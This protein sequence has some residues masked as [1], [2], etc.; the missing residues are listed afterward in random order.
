MANPLAIIG[1]GVGTGLQ[2]YAQIRAA[3]AK[4]QSMRDQ[5]RLEEFAASETEFRS[6]MN[7]LFTKKDVQRV[8]GNTISEMAESGIAVGSGS[9]LE[10]I[11]SVIQSM[12][13]SIM[14]SERE[15]EFDAMMSREKAVS[16]RKTAHSTEQNG[17]LQAIA[18]VLSSA[19]A[20]GMK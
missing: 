18:T 9:N 14:V 11:G 3:K 15:A 12:N 5:A 7:T 19:S 4:A 8:L 2:A 20:I 17:K 16:L 13:E 6:E 1:M 10:V